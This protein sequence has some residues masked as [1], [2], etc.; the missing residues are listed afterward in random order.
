M[1]R[2]IAMVV[3]VLLFAISLYATVAFH[4][5][6]YTAPFDDGWPRSFPYPD[7]WIGPALEKLDS[8]Y[9]AGPRLI[10]IHGEIPRLQ[11]ILLVVVAITFQLGCLFVG[12]SAWQWASR[13][14]LYGKARRFLGAAL[15][16]SRRRTQ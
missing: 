2:R 6:T 4:R 7:T 3:G 1:L 15:Q 12:P 14:E 5:I 16:R 9:P 10:K 11:L 13:N 8:M